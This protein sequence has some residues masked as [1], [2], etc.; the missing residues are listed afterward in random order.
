MIFF[1]ELATR[2][3]AL[4]GRRVAKQHLFS[5]NISLH[6]PRFFFPFLPGPSPSPFGGEK[7]SSH[8]NSV[9]PVSFPR[10]MAEISLLPRLASHKGT[11]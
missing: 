2:K 6:P 4:P 5:I 1:S 11:E 10:V 8:P 9:Q 7:S 3:V